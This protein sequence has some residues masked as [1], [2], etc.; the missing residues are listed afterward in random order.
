MFAGLAITAVS[1]LAVGWLTLRMSATTCRWQPS[2]GA[3]RCT[4][5]MGN[6]DAPGKYDGILGAALNLFGLDMS[7]GRAFML[8]GLWR[9]WGVC[10]INLLDLRTGGPSASPSAT[11]GWPSMM[12]EHLA[13]QGRH[14]LIAGPVCPAC[15]DGCLPLPAHRQ[16]SPFGLEDGH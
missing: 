3:C 5:W 16:P 6:L 9:S 11:R 13:A 2:P 7:S 15:P 12:G 1:A 10:T 8:G 4:T 14:L